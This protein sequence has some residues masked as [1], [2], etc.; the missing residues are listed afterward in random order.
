[1]ARTDWLGLPGAVRR[2]VVS[3]VGTVWHAVPVV[4]GLTCS[5]AVVLT[6]DN[7]GHLFVKGV[8]ADD[9]DGVAAQ[10]VEAAV[11]PLT[12]SVGPRLWAHVEA[13]GWNVLAFEH[14]DGRHADLS[15]G[16]RDLAKVADAVHIAGEVVAPAWLPPLADRFADVLDAD[17]LALL[18]GAALLH[19]DTNPHNL[20]IADKRAHLVDWAMAARGPAWVDVAYTAVRLMEA[21]CT[22]EQALDWAAGCPSWRAAN[23]AAVAA[24]VDGTCRVWEKRVGVAAAGSSNRRF[25]A[26]AGVG[27]TV[28]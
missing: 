5:M 2:A 3:R 13:G 26:L 1:M 22:P 28:A 7:G 14:I 18:D 9:A 21:D 8:P 23:P 10:A 17:Q 6:T 25:R 20:L 24:F 12:L 15:P 11:N 27:A 4:G 19:T 16:S